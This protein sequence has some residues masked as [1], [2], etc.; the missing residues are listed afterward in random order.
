[1]SEGTVTA[2]ETSARSV[3][4]DR[5]VTPAYEYRYNRSQ[6]RSYTPGL[7]MI[8]AY[9]SY[10]PIRVHTPV[11]AKTYA[12]SMVN[13]QERA[14]EH[15]RYV[16]RQLEKED[17]QMKLLQDQMPVKLAGHGRSHCTVCLKY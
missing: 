2:E 12:K 1:M 6:T 3:S 17:R 16:R 10:S 14:L 9:R 7:P 13:S 4:T 5:S 11:R 15:L 8:K